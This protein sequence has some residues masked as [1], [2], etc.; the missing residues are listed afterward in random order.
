MLAPLK[1][2]C[3]INWIC[4]FLI[5]FDYELFFKLYFISFTQYTA[6][7]KIE[8]FHHLSSG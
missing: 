2:L 3:A 4:I 1:T 8:M 7:S 6:L 5:C